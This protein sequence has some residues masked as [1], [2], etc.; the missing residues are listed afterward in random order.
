M[1]VCPWLPRLWAEMAGL[2]GQIIQAA[3]A[4]TLDY[5]SRFR[6]E[7]SKQRT[8][9]TKNGRPVHRVLLPI[10]TC[11]NFQ[12]NEYLRTVQYNSKGYQTHS[13][14]LTLILP[15]EYGINRGVGNKK[16]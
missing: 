8:R 7:R 13:Y 16:M 12:P 15:I 6:P 14:Q 2:S 9:S 3:V 4:F 10:T 1:F 5:I 11:T